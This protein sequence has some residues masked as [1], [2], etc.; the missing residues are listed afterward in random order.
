MS[1]NNLQ[2][3]KQGAYIPAMPLVLDENRKFDEQGQRRLVRYYLAA[4]V[5]GIAAAVH[6]TQFEIRDPKINLLEPVLRTVMDEI[7]KY[8]AKEGRPVLA[9]AGVCGPIEQAVKEAELAKSIGY[10]AALVSP[11]GL[12]DR[13]EAYLLERT[14]AV[15]EVLPVVGFYLQTAVGGRMFSYD[16]WAKVCQIPGVEAI[17][18]A[19]FNRYTTIDVARAIAFSGKDVALYTGND[20]NIVIDLLTEYSFESEEGTKKVRT[21]GG[22]LGHNA[23]WTKTAVDTFRKIKAL[24]SGEALDPQWLT[25]AAQVTDANAAFFDTAHNFAGCIA[26]VH[27]VLHRQGLMKG[28]WCLNPNETLSEGQAEEID[29]V[30][31]MYPELNDDA[32]VKEFLKNEE[33]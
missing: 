29:R 13:S 1:E 33:A 24:K 21:R 9:I 16:Y 31:R 18:C 8:K 11:G 6:T 32:F 26:G 14:E 19:S 4:G 28:I 2:L 27:E 25:L 5:D 20:D 3:L 17:K 7:E 10:D 22:L 15:A 12:N 23:V 30:Y